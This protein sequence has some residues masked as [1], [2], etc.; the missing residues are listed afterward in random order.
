MRKFTYGM[1]LLLVLT[2]SSCGEPDPNSIKSDGSWEDVEVHFTDIELFWDDSYYIHDSNQVDIPDEWKSYLITQEKSDFDDKDVHDLIF[3][4]KKKEV[5][6]YSGTIET[7]V[8][9]VDIDHQNPDEEKVHFFIDV[10]NIDIDSKVLIQDESFNDFYFKYDFNT[11]Y[12][13]FCYFKM[14]NFDKT[15]LESDSFNE[16]RV[17]LVILEHIDGSMSFKLKTEDGITN[18][19]YYSDYGIYFNPDLVD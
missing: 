3:Q 15:Q 11:D 5:E 12:N 19:G 1:L 18:V 17:E 7:V 14:S 10:T 16:I 4:Y 8:E 2:L 9:F 6:Y 13:N